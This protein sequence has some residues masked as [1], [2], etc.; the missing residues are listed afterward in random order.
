MTRIYVPIMSWIWATQSRIAKVV[1]PQSVQLCFSLTHDMAEKYIL[2]KKISF[3]FSPKMNFGS[4]SYFR[5]SQKSKLRF[6]WPTIILPIFCDQIYLMSFCLHLFE[7]L[8]TGMGF[9][10]QGEVESQQCKSALKDIRESD[11]I[12][13][14]QFFKDTELCLP[15]RADTKR[16]PQDC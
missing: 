10:I 8:I 1:A 11:F 9:V 12:K 15:L 16:N 14:P 4:Q 13:N 2:V 6:I 7:S 5:K 3:I